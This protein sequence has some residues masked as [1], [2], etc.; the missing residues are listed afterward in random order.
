MKRY[1]LS[2]GVALGAVAI[3]GL[4]C[5]LSATGLWSLLPIGIGYTRYVEAHLLCDTD[6]SVLLDACRRLSR[7]AR[8]LGL[9][10]DEQYRVRLHRCAEAAK[11]PQSII[12]LGPSYVRLYDDGGVMLE[13][14]GG[15]G[16]CGVLAYPDNF[17]KP[18]PN[19]EYGDRELIPGLW[20][21]EDGYKNNPHNQKRIEALIEKG[22]KRQKKAEG[23]DGER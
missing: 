7:E 17:Q 9:K 3:V 4:L 10:P 22:M 15:L 18:F 14:L 16:H 19:F 5:A 13:M 6:Y 8:Q 2:K 1:V 11:F 12:E 23:V 20:Y 21:Y